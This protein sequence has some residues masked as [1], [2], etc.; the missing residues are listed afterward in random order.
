M[1]PTSAATRSHRPPR[2]VRRKH[3][4]YD[5][6]VFINCPFDDSYEELFRAMVFTIFACGFIPK[7]AKGESNQNLRFQRII[8]LIGESR[9]GIHDLSRIELD[10]MPRNNM[11]LELGVFIGCWRFGTPYDYEKE[12]LVLDSDRHRYNQHTSDIKADDAEFHE[13]R[14]ALL[15]EKVR[16]WLGQRP[17]RNHGYRIPSA[18]ILQERYLR[19]QQEA[20]GLCVEYELTYA[21][22]NFNEYCFIVTEWLQAQQA[23]LQ[24]LLPVL[25]P[26]V[27]PAPSR[28]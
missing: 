24:A 20:P 16:N 25:N 22:L 5:A 4:S 9:Y 8:E 12:Y 1:P 23:K 28:H 2:P 13:N 11:P 21:L 26:Q 3:T 14:P 27:P 19:F 18:D 10:Q 17:F 7:C 6:N 15:I